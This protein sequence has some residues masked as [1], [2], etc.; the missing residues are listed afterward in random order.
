MTQTSAPTTI[1]DK[2]DVPIGSRWVYPSGAVFIV[3][4]RV[5]RTARLV[6]LD[7]SFAVWKKTAFIF[8]DLKRLP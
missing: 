5:G 8:Q 1:N 7:G 6:S 2:Y 4:R 3:D